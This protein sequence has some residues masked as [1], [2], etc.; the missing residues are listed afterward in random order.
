MCFTGG[1]SSDTFPEA[2]FTLADITDETA[3][4][5]DVPVTAVHMW[6]VEPVYD[7]ELGTP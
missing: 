1:M 3:A 2:W 5:L 4:I 6:W 7:P